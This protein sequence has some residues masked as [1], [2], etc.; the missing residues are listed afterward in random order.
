[1]TGLRC[2]APPEMLS[3][4]DFLDGMADACAAAITELLNAA[5]DGQAILN[6]RP[7]V[8]RRHRRAGA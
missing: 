3:K 6:G 4:G 2:F 5:A 7:F 1:M 8:W